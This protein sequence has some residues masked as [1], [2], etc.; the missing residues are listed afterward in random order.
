VNSKRLL[1]AGL[2]LI[3]GFVNF[4]IYRFEKALPSHEQVRL[5]VRSEVLSFEVEPEQTGKQSQINH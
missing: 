1:I 2:L 4:Q 3:L 5:E